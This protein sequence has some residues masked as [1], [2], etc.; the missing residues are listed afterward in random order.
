ML[1]IA[2]HVSHVPHSPQQIPNKRFLVF[3]FFTLHIRPDCPFP[4]LRSLLNIC[5]CYSLYLPLCLARS[6]CPKPFSRGLS[7]SFTCPVPGFLS[8]FPLK[9]NL[10][11]PPEALSLKTKK[12]PFFICCTATGLLKEYHT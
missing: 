10:P 6:P 1:G 8:H 7:P 2:K 9:S 5:L 12:Q 11:L 3:F 4:I